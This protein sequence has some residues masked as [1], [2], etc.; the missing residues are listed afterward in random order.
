MEIR[1]LLD[2]I[3]AC[4]LILNDLNRSYD[5]LLNN[6]EKFKGDPDFMHSKHVLEE[7]ISH[8]EFLSSQ[9]RLQL[10][11]NPK[12]MQISDMITTISQSNN[13]LNNPVIK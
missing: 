5:N 10:R 11:K 3:E 6:E 13:S 12:F 2:Y 4:D 8:Y 7:N 1:E 9:A